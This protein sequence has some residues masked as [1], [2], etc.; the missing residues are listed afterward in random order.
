MRKPYQS[1]GSDEKLILLYCPGRGSNLRPPA[2]RSFEQRPIQHRV[3]SERSINVNNKS[4]QCKYVLKCYM[5]NARSVINKI[6]DLSVFMYENDPDVVFVTETW[7]SSDTL[8]SE[9]CMTGYELYRFDRRHR[10]GGG[11]IIY[12]KND[13]NVVK[14]DIDIF[15]TESI[16]CK[17][18]ARK[19]EVVIGVSYNSPSSSDTYM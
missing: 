10:R 9:L 12:A 14:I 6:A 2:H 16:W 7:T 3:E 19:E 8:D 17:I 13:L 1:P 5:F 4:V 15:D 18:V 11:C